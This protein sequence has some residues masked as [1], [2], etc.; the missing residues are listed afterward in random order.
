M[1]IRPLGNK[2]LVQR[3]EAETLSK[4]GIL[5]PDNAKEKPTQAIVL[6]VGAGRVLE[7]GTVR[8]LDVK[9]GNKVLF[10]KYNGTEVELDG[11]KLLILSEDDILAVLE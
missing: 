6:A 1:N 11:E 10:G 2:I 3:L 7:D 8:P 9:K 4:G 5:I